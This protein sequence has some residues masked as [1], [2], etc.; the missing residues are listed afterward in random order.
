MISYL[1]KNRLF[2]VIFL[3]LIASEIFIVSS[4]PGSDVITGG[5]DASL[6]Y[7]ACVFFLFG[8]FAILSLSNS[9]RKSKA[10]LTAIAISMAY[11]ILDEL[12]QFFVPG[13]TPSILDAV[14]D[15]G[16]VMLAVLVYTYYMKKLSTVGKRTNLNKNKRYKIK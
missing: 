5:F 7:H 15:F 14:V 6:I 2:S 8:F 13:R 16:G 10:V 12:H 1:E 9:K 4:I 11:A 3:I